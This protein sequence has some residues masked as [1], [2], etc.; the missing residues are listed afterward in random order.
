MLTYNR[1]ALALCLLLD[2]MKRKYSVHPIL[3]DRLINGKFHT[4]HNNVREYTE[5]F[6]QF[7]IM[8]QQSVNEIIS[9][10]GGHI[11]RQDTRWRPSI[12]PEERLSVTL[13]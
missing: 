11:Q 4:L 3:S 6:F 8:S 1:K 10:I 5:K 7:N 2:N 12:I 13:R 9:L